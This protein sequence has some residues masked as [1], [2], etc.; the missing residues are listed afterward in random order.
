MAM[1]RG[2]VQSAVLNAAEETACNAFIAGRA[3]FLQIAEIVERV[4]ETLAGLP[5]AASISEV[6]AADA[7][8]R[9][10][11]AEALG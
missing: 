7:Q 6:L 3:R 9:R 1:E 11:A 10:L 2:G 4:M 5:P 8:A